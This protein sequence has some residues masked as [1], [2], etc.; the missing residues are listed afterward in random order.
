MYLMLCPVQCSREQTTC[1]TIKAKNK[2]NQY[3]CTDNNE[4]IIHTTDVQILPRV[5]LPVS[6]FVR[7]F[8]Q[9]PPCLVRC[10]LCMAPRDD[11]GTSRNCTLFCLDGL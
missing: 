5:H 2:S 11:R 4:Q 1:H 10:L 6:P 8:N 7:L 3:I 9:K